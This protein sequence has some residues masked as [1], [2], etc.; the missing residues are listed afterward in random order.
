MPDKTTVKEFVTAL[1]TRKT[2]ITRALDDLFK[3]PAALRGSALHKNLGSRVGALDGPLP[4]WARRELLTRKVS[5]AEINHVNR[6]PNGHK[7]RVRRALVDAIRTGRRVQ[8]FWE[9]HRG[10]TEGTEITTAGK[11][12]ITIVFRSPQRNTRVSTAAATFG[13]IIVGVGA[14]RRARARARPRRTPRPAARA[15]ARARPRRTPR[16][17]AR[18]GA[19]ARPRRTT[20]P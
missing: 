19:R 4:G 10:Q 2:H 1:Q 13:G 8:F 9:L 16:P 6:W 12:V 11:G 17:A 20:T 18:A 15:G 7:R 14:R 5:R 3:N